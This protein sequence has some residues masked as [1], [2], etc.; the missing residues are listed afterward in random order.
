MVVRLGTWTTD[1]NSRNFEIG[2]E[3]FPATEDK[4]PFSILTF[5]WRI[6]L[7][8]YYFLLLHPRNTV[9]QISTQSC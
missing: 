5:K 3:P 1:F 8:N 6:N 4:D 7:K 9:F 2:V